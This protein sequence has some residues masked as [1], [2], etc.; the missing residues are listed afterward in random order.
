MFWIPFEPN[1]ALMQ[2]AT[3]IPVLQRPAAGGRESGRG[4]QAPR[5][6]AVAADSDVR[7]LA[8]S[9]AGRIDGVVAHGQT[10][11][12]WANWL[13]AAFTPSS[14]GERAGVGVGHGAWWGATLAGHSGQHLDGFW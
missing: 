7:C 8:P 5:R 14:R 10:S 11:W 9:A 2:S 1:P 12:G 13:Q 6:G 4:A 3:P